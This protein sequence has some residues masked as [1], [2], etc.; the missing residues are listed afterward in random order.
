MRSLPSLAP[1][2]VRCF[3]ARMILA[4][5]LSLSF[6]LP[7][8]A[9]Q[10]ATGRKRVP[11]MTSD[12]VRPPA[13][14]T[15]TEPS[16]E[17]AKESTAAK[18]DDAAKAK[19]AESD[20]AKITPEES[21][22]R[23]RISRARER[24]NELERAADETELRTTDLRNQLGVSGQTP[25]DRNAIAAEMERVGQELEELRKQERAAAD[26]VNQLLEHGRARNY[27]E[28]EGPKAVQA[29]G[30][31]NA[32]YYR[33]RQAKLQG[34]IATAERRIEL[35]ENRVRDLSQR[36]LMNG[37]KDGGDN[38]YMAQLQKERQDAQQK[39]EEAR[40][41]RMKAQAE[42]D[43]LVEEARRVGVPLK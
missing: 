28:D 32:D 18:P 37:G 6:S 29:D 35:Y 33:G 36:L 27:S 39:M 3:H 40:E 8:L 7:A 25:K 13:T 9:Q 12:D 26:E 24:A 17:P 20:E 22:W 2:A 30:K 42:L 10:P 4:L 11:R 1:K 41:A 14:E 31:P 5:A 19:P 21:S 15:V 16:K 34:E 38:F 23:E 43:A